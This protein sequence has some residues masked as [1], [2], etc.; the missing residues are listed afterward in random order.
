[1][2]QKQRQTHQS[3]EEPSR[4][5]PW[6]RQVKKDLETLPD[7]SQEQRSLLVE[8]TAIDN[9]LKLATG[10]NPFFKIEL[11][12]H[13]QPPGEFIVGP[14]PGRCPVCGKKSGAT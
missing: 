9:A 12:Q 7:P 8:L 13:H 3:W 2:K 6:L 5:T 10:Q 14:A 1:M 4:L 11:P